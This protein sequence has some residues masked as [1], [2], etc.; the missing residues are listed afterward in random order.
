MGLAVPAEGVLL[1]PYIDGELDADQHVVV[2]DLL[3]RNPDARQ[4][5]VQVQELNLLIKVAYSEHA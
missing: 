4:W 1:M 2:E 5:F 3:A